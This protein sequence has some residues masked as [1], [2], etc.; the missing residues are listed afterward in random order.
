MCYY[1]LENYFNIICEKMVKNVLNTQNKNTLKYNVF[2][3]Q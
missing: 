2:I 3:N 1:V